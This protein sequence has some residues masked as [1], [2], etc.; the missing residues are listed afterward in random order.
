MRGPSQ[1]RRDP[2]FNQPVESTGAAHFFT[3]GDILGR[4]DSSFEGWITSRGLSGA[5]ASPGFDPEED[6]TSNLFDYAFIPQADRKMLTLG[7]PTRDTLEISIPSSQPE[8]LTYWL[9]A[10]PSLTGNDWVP[11]LK[12]VKNDWLGELRVREGSTVDG[13]STNLITLPRALEVESLKFFRVR[14]DLLE[15]R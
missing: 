13:R 14:A 11:L 4:E 7:Y 2:A 9:E 5:S 3:I 8:D 10:S 15:N 12:G 1:H 6:G